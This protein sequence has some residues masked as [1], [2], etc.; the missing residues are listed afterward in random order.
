MTVFWE[1]CESDMSTAN[2]GTKYSS[3]WDE[4]QEPQYIMVLIL[5]CSNRTLSDRKVKKTTIGQQ[6]K[7]G[8]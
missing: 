6:N 2:F 3:Y 1:N 7:I 5:T 8:L 4:G